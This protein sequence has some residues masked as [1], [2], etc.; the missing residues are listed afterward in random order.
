MKI[1]KKDQ[2]AIK[3]GASCLGS[4]TCILT[5]GGSTRIP[6]TCTSSGDAVRKCFLALGALAECGICRNCGINLC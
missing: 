1:S 5:T 4:I 2:R 3:G 6:G